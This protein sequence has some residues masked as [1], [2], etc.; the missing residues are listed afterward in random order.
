MIY[1]CFQIHYTQFKEQNAYIFPEGLLYSIKYDTN[2]NYNTYYIIE[3]PGI[4]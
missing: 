1:C 3:I 4:M 2:I